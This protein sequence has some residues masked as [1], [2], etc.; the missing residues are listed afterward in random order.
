MI[1]DSGRIQRLREKYALV[2]PCDWPRILWVD[3]EHP[4]WQAYLED[5]IRTVPSAIQ[6]DWL[7][8]LV[9]QDD[10]QYMGAWF[11]MMLFGWL[12]QIG[13]VTP[14]PGGESEPDFLL[15]AQDQE[16]LIEAFALL[17][18]PEARRRRAWMC[19]LWMTLDSIPRPFVVHIKEVEF[20]PN[21]FVSWE[22]LQETVVHW[23]DTTPSELLELVYPKCRIL[24]EAS[25]NPGLRSVGVVG[26]IEVR[27]ADVTF[28]RK[29]LQKK[30]RQHKARS[31]FPF[32]LAVFLDRWDLS[33]DDV[34][35][36]W[37]GNIRITI[38][39]STMKVIEQGI[40]FSGLHYFGR[41]IRHTSI[42]G[43]LTFHYGSMTKEPPFLVGSYIQNPYAR[44]LVDPRVWP[45]A[46]RFLVLRETETGF[47]MG[48][49]V[50]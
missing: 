17:E 10:A 5:I 3:R 1:F 47:E 44:H 7:H 21:V 40:D 13:D 49:R 28:L 25:H 24:L 42:S 38:E 8:R 22:K 31:S 37:S 27:G 6:Q 41:E 4:T 2:H 23:L 26:P 48:W 50:G 36:A 43:T 45:V 16:I 9:N 15:R 19:R 39:T 33:P 18:P 46:F 29:H 20:S 30:S 12:Q 32:I 35:Q 14:H 11:E 34:V